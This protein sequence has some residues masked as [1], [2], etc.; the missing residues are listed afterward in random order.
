M[1]AREASWSDISYTPRPSLGMRLPSDSVAYEPK[2]SLSVAS[3]AG[4]LFA[5]R[6]VVVGWSCSC[7]TWPELEVGFGAQTSTQDNC[8]LP[9]GFGASCNATSS[10]FPSDF[11]R[12]VQ[13]NNGKSG[14]GWARHMQVSLH[15]SKCALSASLRWDSDFPTNLRT[16]GRT[17]AQRVE[18]RAPTKLRTRGRA[19][20]LSPAHGTQ[21][22]GAGASVL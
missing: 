21:L 12:V 19:V 13:R 17:L 20:V 18:A 16:S 7:K 4:M 3:L 10:F 1:T 22:A 2:C 8:T 5:T 9:R 11:R 15:N 14:R 6:R